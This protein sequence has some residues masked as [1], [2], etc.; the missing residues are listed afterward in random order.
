MGNSDEEPY[1]PE[2]NAFLEAAR[3]VMERMMTMPTNDTER[4][5]Y[6][7]KQAAELVREWA[8]SDGR[9]ID[10]LVER[11]EAVYQETRAIRLPYGG[12]SIGQAVRSGR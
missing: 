9:L 8:N 11:Q 3:V 4:Y 10:M 7:R 2:F 6:L 1:F 12:G 5:L